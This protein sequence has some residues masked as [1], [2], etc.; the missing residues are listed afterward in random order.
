MVVVC[1]GGVVCR[2]VI[3]QATEEN[4][5]SVLDPVVDVIAAMRRGEAV[6]VVDDERRENEGDIIVAAEKATPDLV[7]FMARHG[8]GLICVA[9]EGAALARLGL[10]RMPPHGGGNPHRTA[11]ME[12]VDAHAGITTGISAA[13]RSRTICLLADPQT[14]ADD[15]VRPGHIFPLEAVEGGVLRRP[16]HTEASVDLARMA[17][18]YPAGAICEIL[19]DDGA[20]A[21]L[22][23]LVPFAR[24]HG[25]KLTSVAAI[26]MHRRQNEKMVQLEETIT[27]PTDL[28]PFMVRVYRSLIDG[29]HH[30]ALLR[31]DPSTQTAPLIRVHSE[32]LT[33]DAFGS[34]RCDCGAQ[35]RTAMKMIADEGVGALLYMRQEGRGI[36]LASKLKAYAL[37]ERGLDTVEANEQLGFEADAR[38]YGLAAQMLQDLG[39]SSCRLI[40]N[41]P[42]K[43]SGLETYGVKVSQRIPLVA[44]GS[45]FNAK[46]L[47]TKKA[48]LGHLL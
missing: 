22:D 13:D 20:M 8:R 48:K 9:M 21:R 11:F 26:A 34:L 15:L 32:C 33:G 10:A 5:V 17:G 7:N 35:L 44:G 31:G 30:L 46:Y 29:E 14:S 42:K 37:Q 27:L 23:D 3:M 18:L 2:G 41:N 24:A 6:V 16:G 43:I 25:L 39:I 12:S 38:D 45:P 4:R 40:T 19:R 47:E 1:P 28:G 36:G